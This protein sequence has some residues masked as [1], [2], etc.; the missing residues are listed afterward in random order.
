M[1]A[2]ALG[3][4]GPAEALPEDLRARETAPRGRRAV[5]EFA[6]FGGWRGG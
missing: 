5:A 1:A 6:H 3:H 4:P 2:A